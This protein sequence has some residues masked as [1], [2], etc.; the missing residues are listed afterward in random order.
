MTSHRPVRRQKAAC[1]NRMWPSV[2]KSSLLSQCD[3]RSP[4]L[5]LASRNHKLRS[6]DLVKG[7]YICVDSLSSS[8]RYNFFAKNLQILFFCCLSLV[9]FYAVVSLWFFLPGQV[10]NL[11]A[12]MNGCSSSSSLRMSQRAE[13]LLRHYNRQPT[14]DRR[15]LLLVS[16]CSKRIYLRRPT[17]G[18]VT[19][20]QRHDHKDRRNA[21]E[22]HQ[23][24]RTDAE[25]KARQQPCH[26]RSSRQ[27]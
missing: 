19:G 6:V 7:K 4:S 20:Q 15:P 3:Y 18:N 9:L 23:V 22:G 21:D 1:V 26:Q 25:K 27:T 24:G 14:A 12:M 8:N 13:P 17:R 5:A 16:Q 2:L 11:P 10:I